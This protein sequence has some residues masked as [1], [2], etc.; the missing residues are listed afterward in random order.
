MSS[1]LDRDNLEAEI[2][3]VEQTVKTINKI[4]HGDEKELQ[5][6]L[7]KEKQIEE[8]EKHKKV[9]AEIN[10]REQYQKLLNGFPGK[11]KEK[12]M[13][14]FVLIAFMNIL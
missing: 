1:R 12:I 9:L 6:A 8:R 7:E 4:I 10:A 13:K 3:E 2:W 14:N 5:E 11:G